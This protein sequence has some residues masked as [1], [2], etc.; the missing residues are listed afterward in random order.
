[1]IWRL[2]TRV[3]LKQEEDMSEYEEFKKEK[4]ER[5]N[6]AAPLES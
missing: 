2:A 6:Q 5:F 1:M 4:Q 3:E